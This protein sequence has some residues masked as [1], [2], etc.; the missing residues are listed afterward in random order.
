MV[1]TESPRHLSANVIPKKK[2]P[3]F[4]GSLEESRPRLRGDDSGET[5]G[6]TN[7]HTVQ[8]GHGQLLLTFVAVIPF[9]DLNRQA[10]LLVSRG[11]DIAVPVLG[12]GRETGGDEDGLGG[13]GDALLV[14]HSG[15]QVGVLADSEAVDAG[16][17]ILRE[18]SIGA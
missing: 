7:R 16:Q 11:G 15:R 12:Q 2:E 17:E 9:A 13:A 3:H 6:V 18:R 5:V 1:S 8:D 10:A 14:G 4:W